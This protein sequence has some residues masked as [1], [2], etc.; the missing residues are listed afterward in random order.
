MHHTSKVLHR[1][2]RRLLLVQGGLVAAVAAGFAVVTGPGAVPAVLFGGA[3]A[4]FNTLVSAERLHRATAVAGQDPSGGMASLYM[5]AVIR[6]VATP[7]LIVVGIAALALDPVAILAGFAVAQL[8]YLL[9]NV[10]TGPEHAD[11]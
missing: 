6:F 11:R 2:L 7:A 9:N 1:T 5:G 3:I 10:N 4:L 8:G